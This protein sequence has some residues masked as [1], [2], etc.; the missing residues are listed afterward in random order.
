M[1]GVITEAPVRSIAPW[2]AQSWDDVV[3]AFHAALAET[4]PSEPSITPDMES[5]SAQHS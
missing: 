1:S 3:A 4:D 2:K 5:I